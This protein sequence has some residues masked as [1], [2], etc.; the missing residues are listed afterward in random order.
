MTQFCVYVVE[1]KFVC[2]TRSE[3]KQTKASEFGA[4]TVYWRAKQGE[5]AAHTQKTSMVFRKE[6]LKAKLGGK[7]FKLYD[8]FCLVDVR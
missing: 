7:V 4:E 3:A 6:F 1:L 5:W 8:F 2:P